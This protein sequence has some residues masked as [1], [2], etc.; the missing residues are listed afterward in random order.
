MMQS[1]VEYKKVT[2]VTGSSNFDDDRVT[3]LL[4]TDFEEVEAVYVKELFFHFPIYLLFFSINNVLIIM[5][6]IN[7]CR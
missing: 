2:V 6:I 3:V 1:A 5:L 4:Y 7:L